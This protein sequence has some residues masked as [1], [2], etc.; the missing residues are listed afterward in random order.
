MDSGILSSNSKIAAVGPQSA[1]C[2]SELGT[3]QSLEGIKTK[4]LDMDTDG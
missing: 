4:I 2:K 1:L 3:A